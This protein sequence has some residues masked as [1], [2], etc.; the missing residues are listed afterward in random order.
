MKLFFYFMLLLAASVAVGLLIAHD[1]GY[2]LINY[3][4]WTIEAPLWLVVTAVLAL[5]L[6]L[7]G[8]FSLVSSAQSL[9]QGMLLFRRRQ[10]KR[11]AHINTEKGFLALAEGCWRQAEQ[12]L[13]QGIYEQKRGLLN[14]LG[15]AMAAQ[16]Q[17]NEERRDDY[18]RLAHSAN[19]SADLAV[20]LTQAKLQFDEGQY[21]QC[22]A[23]LE[24]LHR[25]SPANDYTMRLL[26]QVYGK[27]RDWQ[28][29]LEHLLLMKKRKLLTREQYDQLAR[30]VS[31]EQLLKLQAQ[32][33]SPIAWRKIFSSF[34][35]LYQREE[36]FLLLYLPICLKSDAKAA[37]QLVKEG[38][39]YA[40]SDELVAY[41]GQI[42][43]GD[44]RELL[45]Y[46]ESLLKK[47]PN[48]AML[49]LTLGRLCLKNQLWGKAQQ[50]L[51][52]AVAQAHTPEACY[53][54]ARLHKKLGDDKRASHFFQA[55]LS[56]AIGG[57]LFDVEDFE[58][59]AVDE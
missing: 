48:N 33:A 30:E 16:E 14:Y 57:N 31:L 47:R 40:W 25:L 7:V 53:E 52:A 36:E 49:R 18:L 5:V 13:I 10:M 43:G 21:E 19:E 38:L 29:L 45:A 2:M 8:M 34:P 55:G 59:G 41:I 58:A 46:G 37:L 27:L 22:L 17:G 50:H 26:Q 56:L 11:R 4:V 20:G 51:D 28:R 32:A 42:E 15:A 3:D 6:L 9:W 1:P 54:L 24:R 23:T 44:G 39:K 12:K 35:K